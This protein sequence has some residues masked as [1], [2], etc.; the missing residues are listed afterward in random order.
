M[1]LARYHAGGTVC[2]ED[3][4]M[5][6]CPPGGLLVRTEACGLCSGELMDWY[7]DRK[8]P[9]VLGHEV[10]GV[11]IESESAPFPVGC[12][13][14]AHHHAPCGQCRH[15]RKGH[16]VHC[17]VWKRSK[18]LPGGMAEYFGVPQE[19]LAD[20]LRIDSLRARDAA[21]I[22]PLACVAKSIRRAR[23]TKSDSVAVLG[24]GVMGLLHMFILRDQAIGFDLLEARREWARTKGLNIGDDSPPA[25]E[26]DV[27]FVCPG[28][29]KALDQA[30]EMIAPGGRILLFSPL[31]PGV[32]YQVDLD[33]QYFTDFELIASYS[34]GPEDTALSTKWLEEKKVV[35]EDVVSDFVKLNDLPAAYKE[36]KDM[37]ILKVM[38]EF[39]SS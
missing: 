20:T 34:C 26:F 38:V 33:K 36:M 27:V 1:K 10:V 17:P 24:L 6:S 21:L 12:R 32:P 13:V 19:N 39:S 35:A 23:V 25:G 29:A 14:F 4:L 37:T 5:P 3:D 31:P 8:A 9:H 22:E 15:C 11:V 18:L 16:P 2:I 30:Y 28:S 7:L